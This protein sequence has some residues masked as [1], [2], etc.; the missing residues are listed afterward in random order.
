MPSCLLPF[1]HTA[2]GPGT[3]MPAT[4]QS[5]PNGFLSFALLVN[6]LPLSSSRRINY[7]FKT[8]LDLASHP[9][10]HAKTQIVTKSVQPQHCENSSGHLCSSGE[11]SPPQNAAEPS[12]SRA[13][14]DR[15]R[16]RRFLSISTPIDHPQNTIPLLHTLK[17]KEV[18]YAHNGLSG[19]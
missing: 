19:Q 17:C 7:V 13:G 12:S 11:N 6:C 3:S 18:V 2:Y 15:K 10:S 4:K 16:V 5:G 9:K 1:T 8:L 14:Q